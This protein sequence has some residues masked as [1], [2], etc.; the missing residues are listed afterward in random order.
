VHLRVRVRVCVCVCVNSISVYLSRVDTSTGIHC[1]HACILLLMCVYVCR[2]MRYPL[3]PL[4]PLYSCHPPFSA[5]SLECTRD[6]SLSPAVSLFPPFPYVS[7]SL[8]LSPSLPPSRSHTRARARALSRS[9]THS[10]T[11]THSG[12]K[13]LALC[14]PPPGLHSQ[15]FEA[16]AL[17]GFLTWVHTTLTACEAK[18][19]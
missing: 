13:T 19:V 12:S 1:I 6:V 2:C 11:L 17:G 9:F 5:D 18:Q 10:N 4:Y 3:Y 14:V 7:L 16:W 15:A 8:S